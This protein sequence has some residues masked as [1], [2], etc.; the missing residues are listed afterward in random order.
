M[1]SAVTAAVPPL[2][3]RMALSAI[4]ERPVPPL[5]TDSVPEVNLATS[6]AGTSAATSDLNVGTPAEP[7]GAANTLFAS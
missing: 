2:P 3:I 5:A 1:A 4:V 7:S 6:S